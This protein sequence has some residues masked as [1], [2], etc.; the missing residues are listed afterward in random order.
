V[1]KWHI[2]IGS[3]PFRPEYEAAKKWVEENTL[4]ISTEEKARDVYNRV[5]DQVIE[6]FR[7]FDGH[8]SQPVRV[9]PA[10]IDID[11]NAIEVRIAFE[12]IDAAMLWKLAHGGE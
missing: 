5:Q 3:T 12:D 4:P 6:K 10:N 2:V 1:S 8:D 9:I 7:T 11:N